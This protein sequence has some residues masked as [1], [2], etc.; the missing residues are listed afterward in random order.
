MARA[1]HGILGALVGSI[2][3][4][5]CFNRN[6][7][8]VIRR[9]AIDI[10]NPITPSRTAN[11]SNFRFAMEVYHALKPLLFLTLSVK[12]KKRSVLSEFL[13]LN[14]NK[15]IVNSEIDFD[16]LII[17]KPTEQPELINLSLKEDDSSI[18]LIS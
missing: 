8:N 9:K 12:N 17:F 7:T 4:Y 1:K 15:S 3:E 18:I 14:L 13:R 6:Q 16:K 5:V 10:Y 11:K 2:D